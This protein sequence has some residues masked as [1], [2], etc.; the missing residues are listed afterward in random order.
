MCFG[1]PIEQLERR[2]LLSA[3]LEN[4][5]LTV[6]GTEGADVIEFDRTTLTN[7][8]VEVNDDESNF[9]FAAINRIIVRALGGNDEVEFNNRNPIVINAI[10]FGDAGND[11]L[12]G[13]D[14]RDTIYGAD[15]NDVLEGKSN[16]DSLV[17]QRGNDRLE[18]DSGNDILKG[19]VGNDFLEGGLHRDRLFGEAGQ[20]DLK[21][22][23]GVDSIS[24]GLGNDDF[25]NSDS[26][27]EI[28]DRVAEDN[29]PN[30]N[31]AF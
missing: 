30:A 10:I 8:K 4:G 31:P 25:D 3:V 12:E 17:G 14:G 1:T 24:G 9:D 7:M 29:G 22:N 23:A 5:V 16:S 6:T 26:S 13:G 27:S 2:H 28:L 18:G 11:S 15:G 19:G 20:D 21:G